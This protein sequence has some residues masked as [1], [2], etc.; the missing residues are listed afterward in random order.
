MA[1][2]RLLGQLLWH[3]HYYSRLSL[4]ERESK[5]MEE[6]LKKLSGKISS[7]LLIAIASDVFCQIAR[8]VLHMETV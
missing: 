1:P 6:G 2:G 4:T 7:T 8:S 5:K 3:R